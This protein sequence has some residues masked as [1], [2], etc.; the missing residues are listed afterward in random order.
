MRSA[1]ISPPDGGITPERVDGWHPFAPAQ[2]SDTCDR[3]S[4]R[5]L[6]TPSSWEHAGD[7]PAENA[8][9]QVYPAVLNV[10]QNCTPRVSPKLR[11]VR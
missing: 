8:D 4:F 1:L 10:A 2:R 5:A 9:R 6:G 3:F 11:L 7:L